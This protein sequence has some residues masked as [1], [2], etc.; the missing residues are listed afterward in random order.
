MV[1]KNGGRDEKTYKENLFMELQ[2]IE[3]RGITIF[4]EGDPCDP[5]TATDRMSVNEDIVYM[6]DYV[7]EEGILRELRFDK[8]SNM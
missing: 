1:K 3:N 7:F 5:L 6:R 8:V 4:F 2:S